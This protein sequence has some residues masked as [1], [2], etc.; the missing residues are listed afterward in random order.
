[1]H[2]GKFYGWREPRKIKSKYRINSVYRINYKKRQI[3]M[4]RK[5][6]L[7]YDKQLRKSAEKTQELIDNY[8]KLHE[9][10]KQRLITRYQRKIKDINRRYRRQIKEMRK[11]QRD[12]VDSLVLRYNPIYTDE[13]LLEIL[14]TEVTTHQSEVLLNRYSQILSIESVIDRDDFDKL[15]K[16]IQSPC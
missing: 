16:M 6:M 1:M 12:L 3:A 9:L 10:Q 13:K 15:H 2:G 4:I 11:F 8:Q 5:E 14:K 7:K